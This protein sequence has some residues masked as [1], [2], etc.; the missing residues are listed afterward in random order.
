MPISDIDGQTACQANTSSAICVEYIKQEYSNVQDKLLQSKLDST[1]KALVDFSRTMDMDLN[2]G[3]YAQRNANLLNSQKFVKAYN[4][5][6]VNNTTHDTDITRR[7]FE[8]NEYYYY[9]KLD[10]LFFLQVFFISSMIMAIIIYSF[11]KGILT[12]KMSGILTIVLAILVVI[13][14]ISRYYY[15]SRIRDKR[16]W[17]RKNFG[18]EEDAKDRPDF[19]KQCPGPSAAPEINLNAIFDDDTTQCLAE[20]NAYYKAWKDSLTDMANFDTTS[21]NLNTGLKIAPSCKNI[22]RS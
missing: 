19:I 20:S 15:T 21:V 11:R 18:H 16:L 7:Q 9:N 2:A 3:R 13:I 5:S 17:H 6:I 14:G 4:E 12:A 8:I 10:T 1:S 22:L